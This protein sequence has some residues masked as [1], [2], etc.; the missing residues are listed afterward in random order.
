MASF[1]SRNPV[2]GKAFALLL[3]DAIKNVPGAALGA[4]SKIH[5]SKD[6]SFNP[7]PE[8]DPASY[9]AGEADF[10]GYTSGG[11]TATW[12]TALN[13]GSAMVSLSAS[14]LPVVGSADPQVENTLTGYWWE[15]ANGLI[16]AERFPDGESVS[17]AVPGDYLD[18]LALFAFDL[19]PSIPG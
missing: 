17:M 1:A 7:T 5:F 2:I 3:L 12:S 6:P 14:V 9:A 19:T 15:N 18:L 16:L 8:D 11:Y 10:S 13:N 4:T